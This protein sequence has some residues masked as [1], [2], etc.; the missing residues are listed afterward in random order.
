MVPHF[1]VQARPA[2]PPN[3]G[4]LPFASI[5]QHTPGLPPPPC[6]QTHAAGSDLASFCFF[7]PA[8]LSF[9]LLLVPLPP[10]WIVSSLF[11]LES[12]PAPA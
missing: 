7:L 8:S 12:T 3:L 5:R 9:S 4:S 11:W 10:S 1:P 2:R 6:N